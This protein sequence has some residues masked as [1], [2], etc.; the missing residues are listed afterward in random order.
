MGRAQMEPKIFTKYAHHDLEPTKHCPLKSGVCAHDRCDVVQFP[1]GYM[2]SGYP[3]RWWSKTSLTFHVRG[4]LEIE[5]LL[6]GVVSFVSSERK[7][8]VHWAKKVGGGR[9]NGI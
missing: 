6:E 8:E 3:V 5:V 4:G 7:M 1:E 2:S 9:S